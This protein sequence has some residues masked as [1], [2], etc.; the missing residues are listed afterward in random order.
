MITQN[1]FDCKDMPPIIQEFDN[2]SMAARKPKTVDEKLAFDLAKDLIRYKLGRGTMLSCKTASILR[3]LSV[4][5]EKKHEPLFKNMC[6]R[7]DLNERNLEL[8]CKQIADEILGS[9]INWGR[10][11]VLYTFGAKVAEYFN[12]NGSDVS[13][14]VSTWIG[15]YMLTKSEWIKKAGGWV[16]DLRSKLD[17]ISYFIV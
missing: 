13:D 8:T 4:Q 9:D 7:L 1:N 15:N 10:I 17:N 12:S 3:K 6:H 2:A 11:V 5:I 16:S 14:E